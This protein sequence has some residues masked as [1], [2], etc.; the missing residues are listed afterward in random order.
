[1]PT[2]RA[3]LWTLILLADLRLD[4]ADP[5]IKKPLSAIKTHF[6]DPEHGIYSPREDHF[7]IPCLNRNMVDLDSCFN[8]AP[9]ERS[10]RAL[11]F[12]RRYQRFDDGFYAA[13]KHPFCTNTGGYGRHTRYWGIVKLLNPGNIGRPLLATC[14]G[15]A[16]TSCRGTAF[17]TAPT[18]PTR[19]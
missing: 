3:T 4:P 12:F 16:S 10:Q 11:D 8:G 1:M 14:S 5:R 19:S 15:A 2:Y 7:P 9:G 17:A 13:P 6:F 18:G